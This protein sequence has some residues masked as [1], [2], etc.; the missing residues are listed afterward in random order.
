MPGMTKILV[1]DDDPTARLLMRATLTRAGFEVGVAEG[2]REA[3]RRFA[4]DHFDM[5]L[6]DVEMPDMDGLN[7]CSVL[8]AQA[9]ETLPIV[10]VTGL[11]DVK[12]VEAAFAAGATDFIS[13]PINWALIGHRAH[14]LVRASKAFQ[15]LSEAHAQSKRAQA[16]LA[17][18][19]SDLSSTL[20]AIPDLLFELD[21]EG[22]YYSVRSPRTDL[23]VAPPENLVGGLIGDTMAAESAAICMAALQ[24]ANTKGF[25]RGYQF[26]LQL[27]ASLK[28]F[29]LSV[30]RKE[31]VDAEGPRFIVLSRDI[32]ERKEV[33]SR[34]SRL[35]YFDSLTGL[36]N[37][38][39]FME[40]L[41]RELERARRSQARLAILYM[42][43]DGFKDIN[44]SLGHDAGDLVLQAVA[45][46]LREVV[47][48]SDMVSRT[49]GASADEKLARL[50]GDEFTL[51][52]LDL[53]DG[54]QALS[55][56]NR[57]RGEMQRPFLVDGRDLR[58]TASIG[59]AMFPDD[60]LDVAT[61]V[62][63]ADTAMYHGKDR[64]RDNCQFYS[65]SLTERAVHRMEMDRDMRIALEQGTFWL[66]YQPQ[67]D[68]K[69]GRILAVEA[70]IRWT[71]PEHGPIAPLDFIPLAETNGLIVPIGQWVL[72][73]AC[74]AAVRWRD[75]GHTLRVAVNLSA[76]QL[77]SPDLVQS[78]QE[79]LDQTGLAPGMLELEVTESALMEDTLQT[80]S[81]LQALRA[82]GVQLALDD[83]GT[84]YSSMS[85]LTRMPLNHLKIDRSFVAGL[86]K[87]AESDSIVRA[88][89]S[90]A[91]AMR[92][93]VTAEGVETQ[94]Q[95]ERLV[96]IGCDVLQGYYY[97]RP[98]AADALADVLVQR[99]GSASAT[100]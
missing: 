85:Y 69:N 28:W 75:Q 26:K 67:V 88:I 52:I 63:H 99:A 30:S 61:L 27:G 5:V 29:E 55:A 53:V 91:K 56:G 12:S 10:M 14:Y 9:G 62:K 33:E 39:Y 95:A 77:R 43:L 7:L 13:K 96:D 90:M 68:A 19:Q 79:A 50:G 87:D 73:S 34:I 57:I 24:E 98:A 17:R 94:A 59:I 71:H 11:D 1:V 23:L 97:C 76:R 36:P 48:P 3:L 46:R 37:R 84:G 44:D 93:R 82:I 74:E 78:V 70:L 8:R 21:L 60:G 65:A 20:N 31:S 25:S 49:A 32:S 92:L 4:L 41:T 16:E 80:V 66:A 58:L 54:Q 51:L 22:R 83:F 6:L 86:L 38:A 64:G 89:V 35:A 100:T 81:T 72:L 42:D 2:G 15:E 45:D 18:S 47:R 40:R